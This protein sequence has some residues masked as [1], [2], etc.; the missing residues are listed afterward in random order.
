MLNLSRSP[1]TGSTVDQYDVVVVGGGMV[2]AALACALGKYTVLLYVH[3]SPQSPAATMTCLTGYQKGQQDIAWKLTTLQM[4][5][6]R[7]LE[8]DC[9]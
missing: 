6:R 7:L 5:I 1:S 8:T 3:E 9:S 2:G 4:D